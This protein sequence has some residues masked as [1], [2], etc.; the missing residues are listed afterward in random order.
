MEPSKDNQVMRDLR[1]SFEECATGKGGESGAEQPQTG[2]G[3]EKSPFSTS[4]GGDGNRDAKHE[5]VNDDGKNQDK[6]MEENEKE[7]VGKTTYNR[8]SYGP[9]TESEKAEWAKMAAEDKAANSAC[10]RMEDLGGEYFEQ[11][12]VTH[13]E[14]LQQNVNEKATKIGVQMTRTVQGDSRWNTTDIKM[15]FKLL[16]SIDPDMLIMDCTGN[17]K[18]VKSIADMCKMVRMDFNGYLDIANVK[19]GKPS[20]G[21]TRTTLSFWIATDCV[22][23]N[24]WEI[25][26]DTTFQE[27]LMM[28]QCRI[29]PTKLTE[30]Q[31]KVVGVLEGKSP[32]HTNRMELEQKL[33]QHLSSKSK[34][35]R[36]IPVN[37]VPLTEN[38]TQ[39]LG[40][41]VGSKDARAAETILKEHPFP[42]LGIILYSWKRSHKNDYNQRIDQH[43]MIC[44]QSKAFKIETMDLEHTLPL[45]N[46][47]MRTS[48]VSA[49]IVDVC[50]ATHSVRTGTVYVQYLEAHR[51]SV[52]ATILSFIEENCNPPGSHFGDTATLANNAGTESVTPTVNSLK[53]QSSK[54]QITIPQSRFATHL[55]NQISNVYQPIVAP[56]ARIPTAITTKPK[57]FSQAL[58][59]GRK[60]NDSDSDDDTTLTPKTKN[61]AGSS[62]GSGS[63]RSS[64]KTASELKLE[65]DNRRL[66]DEL[67]KMNNRLSEMERSHHEQMAEMQKNHRLQLQAQQQQLA[68]MAAALTQL[69][70][71]FSNKDTQESPHRKQ[72]PN[73]KTNTRGSPAQHQ[74]WRSLLTTNATGA[75][76]QL[77]EVIAPIP[78]HDEPM[79]ESTTPPDVGQQSHV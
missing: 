33:S 73:K 56:Q 20:E 62:G 42:D 60:T 63:S 6:I 13:L 28:G 68:E 19:W 18:S 51:D 65:E 44:Q 23:R 24:L 11:L 38:G 53:S 76:Q 45:F 54:T 7:S 49:A 50:T 29:Q 41:T 64:R 39:V 61:S 37:I 74:G 70:T 66:Q 21:K 57:S 58:L 8:I 59:M 30:S 79:Q 55:S 1:T 22:K 46:T 43:K 52:R 35:N 34:Q 2:L 12:E 4:R 78:Q 31:S 47:Y 5:S 10:A 3:S 26:Q 32:Q 48:P 14:Q 36:S 77:S 69:R 67:G 15:I 75:I 40:F 9:F 71:E 17:T 25:R 27:F 72:P 16:Q